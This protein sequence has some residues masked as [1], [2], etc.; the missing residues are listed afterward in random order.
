MERP[1]GVVRDWSAAGV[2]K[3]RKDLAA[4]DE[5]WKRLNNPGAPIPQQVDHRLMGSA[6]ARGHWELDVLKRWQRDP[7]FY[8]EQT[9][10]PVA[11]ALTVPR[12]EER[13]VGKE[14]GS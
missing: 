11:E 5:R 10:T 3:Q 14:R 13:R 6:L 1:A 4:F 7:N 9:L 2:E 12:S 8:I